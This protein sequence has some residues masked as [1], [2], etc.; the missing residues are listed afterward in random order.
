MQIDR[1]AVHL[2]LCT[3]MQAADLG[4]RLC[5]HASASVL[6]VWILVLLPVAALCA[7][8]AQ[9]SAV[10]P[11]LLLWWAKPWLD[12]SLLFA[13]SRATFGIETRAQDLWDAQREVWWSQWWRTWTLRRLTSSRA[14]TQPIVQ[15]EGQR[16]AAL[17]RRLRELHRGRVGVARLLT[18]VF[19]NVEMAV[20][21][22]CASLWLWFTPQGI[23]GWQAL[24]R[25]QDE[26]PLL[27]PLLTTF[28][29]YLVAIAIVE[30]FYVAAGFGV[31]LN[32]RVE[33]EAWDIEQDLRHA[34]A[35]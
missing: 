20:F 5:Q 33:L 18:L 12:R 11:T 8:T 1:L 14:C 30:P 4:V 21:A 23:S 7:A 19:S 25:W 3:P 27:A 32:R 13:L 26:S 17:R 15:L 31:Y 22:G 16:G 35:Q 34:F 9:I 24:V 10:L 28:L 6:R 29:P 2:R